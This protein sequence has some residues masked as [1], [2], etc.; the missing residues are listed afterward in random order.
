MLRDPEPAH[1]LLA[2]EA[3]T[4]AAAHLGT[5]VVERTLHDPDDR[6][7]RAAVALAAG[8]GPRG[9]PL[10][11]PHATARAWPASQLAALRV[12]PRLVR[13]AGTLPRE[14]LDRM[15][16]AVA[17]LDPPPLPEER[18]DLGELARAIGFDALAARFTG[19]DRVRLGAGRLL[20]AEGGVRAL[21]A[22][23]A[24][25]A[26]GS[27]DLAALRA[28]ATSRLRT[29]R[30]AAAPKTPAPPPVEEPAAALEPTADVEQV[31]SAMARALA[32]PDGVVRAE[33]RSALASLPQVIVESWVR[34]AIEPDAGSSSAVD[35]VLACAVAEQ[36][37]IPA[38]AEPILRAAL[39]ASSDDR[40]PYLRALAPFA[41]H[42][43]H[44]IGA[45]RVLGPAERADAVR[46]V[47]RLGGR[48]G[49]LALE[50]LRDD[51]AGPVR[52][53]VLEA[54]EEAA[55]PSAVELAADLLR[56]DSS[57]D[58]RRAAVRLVGG[59]GD[60]DRADALRTALADPDADVRAAAVETLGAEAAG[61]FVPL[62]L[63]ALRDQDERV[64]RAAVERLAS[65]GDDELPSVWDAI[66][67]LGAE[68]RDA[69]LD[70]MDD[71]HPHRLAELALENVRS[72]ESEERILAVTLA[73]RAGTP[74]S[75][76]AVLEALSDPDPD[77][78]RTAAGQ[79]ATLRDPTAIPALARTLADPKAE[80]RIEAVRALGAVDD[81]TVPE[82]LI[83][84]LKDPEIRVRELAADA[85]ARR[86][87][88]AVAQRLCAALSSP[89]LRRPA[90]DVLQRMGSAAVDPLIDVVM[91][92]DAD[93]ARAA[94]L[95]IERIAGV[96]RFAAALS[97]TLPEYRLRAVRVLGTIGGTEAGDALLAA[98]ADPDV[99]VRA[100]AA[101]LLGELGERRAV[102]ALR[103]TFVS[104]PVLEVAEAAER[105]LTRLGASTG[106]E[107]REWALDS[108]AGSGW[109]DVREPTGPRIDLEAADAD[110]EREVA[111]D[112][113]PVDGEDGGPAREG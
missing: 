59:A 19:S 87:S 33:A 63:A 36:V 23:V 26:S 101:G 42:P 81:D 60:A 4:L 74:E 98:L 8:Q 39:A 34:G 13:E 80:V 44:L 68:R 38:L 22:V 86:R 32:D 2:A 73:A 21:R 89:D 113:E 48:P 12:L 84:A 14:L 58:V 64:W 30:L 7:R 99:R 43:E 67:D 6:V 72:P 54:L 96:G 35:P 79:V 62:L 55:H 88:P 16:L 11:I 94:G 91:T 20:A 45:I 10:L 110:A 65:I 108:R 24:M 75:E 53:A 111:A 18:A 71:R 28:A 103:R 95:L 107:R 29:L 25:P 93:A 76:A 83:D 41:S 112:R 31:L 100:A 70:A 1:R 66:R 9:V 47:W 3:L 105:S 46:M 77:V 50:E 78:R 61:Q 37:P 109:L 90:G 102:S 104:D 5:G 92:A 52:I 69:V 56:R 82:I 17:A 27:S 49:V 57:P 106:A 40:G 85:L 51:P 97:S 15:L